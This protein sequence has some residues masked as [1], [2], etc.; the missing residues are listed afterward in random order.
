[1]IFI[2]AL[3]LTGITIFMSLFLVGPLSA[4]VSVVSIEPE[5][6]STPFRFYAGYG[7]L[8]NTDLDRKGDFSRDGFRFLFNGE[9]E[10]TPKLRLINIAS[11]D[12]NHYD[13]SSSSRFQWKNVHF[14]NY[15]P[16]FTW[17]ADEQWTILAAPIVRLNMEGDAKV[18]EGRSSSCSIKVSLSQHRELGAYRWCWFGKRMAAGGSAWTIDDSML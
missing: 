16:L 10:F 14:A 7:H 6:L 18:K 1:M 2:R 12:F 15:V 17:D 13:F 11:Y 5:Q 8:F 4:Q 9:V 3:T